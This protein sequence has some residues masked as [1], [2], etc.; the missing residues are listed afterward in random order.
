MQC[1][2]QCDIYK[3][4][5]KSPFYF[6]VCGKGFG[7]RE[8]LVT[9]VTI[10]TGVKPYTCE[11]CDSRFSCVGNLI[12]HKKIRP[13]TCGLPI[14]KVTKVCKR[15]GV[16]C[17]GKVPKVV[18][19]NSL[20]EYES[21][22]EA[23]N[24]SV[25]EDVDESISEE[26]NKKEIEESPIYI[27]EAPSE[28]VCEQ[29][30][31]EQNETIIQTETPVHEDIFYETEII[32]S[33]DTFQ[34][35]KQINPESIEVKE[36]KLYDYVNIEIK[37]M[38]DAE[39]AQEAEFQQQNK[40]KFEIEYISQEIIE[41]VECYEDDNID[42]CIENETIHENEEILEYKSYIE[43]ISDKYHCKI[44]PKAYLNLNISIKHLKSVHNILITNYNYEDAN[45]S[46]K[47]L[48]SPKHKCKFCARKYTSLILLKKHEIVHGKNGDLIHKCVCCPSYFEDKTKLDNHQNAEHKDRLECLECKKKFNHPEKLVNHMKYKHQTEKKFKVKKYSFV[49][50][51]C[52]KLH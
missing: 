26:V 50:S 22:P 35:F 11:C 21:V 24:E 46:R 36:M 41:H 28:V 9:H 3:N 37:N 7:Y 33:I 4:C 42:E 18:L 8:S 20:N 49:C 31:I 5:H 13:D 19:E 29:K 47:P 51:V 43:K 27:I 14:Y 1:K 52:G 15:A 44:C 2:Y 30:N 38:E 39:K 25:P 6:K 17:K 32:E 12:K 40:I 34:N 10:H 48:K 45:R 16:K 23:V